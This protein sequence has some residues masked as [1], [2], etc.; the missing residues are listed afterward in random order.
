MAKKN[1]EFWQYVME[2]V[3]SGIPGVTSKAM[4][5][6]Y[7]IYKNGTI[8]AIIAEGTL[9]FKADER[10][11]ADFKKYGSGPFIYEMPN[12]KEMS[13]SYWMLPE[14]IMEDREVLPD[15]VD[16]AVAASKRAKKTKKK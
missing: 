5:G 16:K 12:G 4:F 1:S 6:G 11:E 7:G 2:D 15:W 10:T 9:Y 8:F 3:L 13:M 14:D